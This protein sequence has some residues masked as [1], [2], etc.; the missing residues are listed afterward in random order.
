MSGQKGPQYDQAGVTIANRTPFNKYV[1]NKRQTVN[2]GFVNLAT[3]VG[4]N[5]SITDVL[6][7]IQDGSFRTLEVLLFTEDVP[8]RLRLENWDELA[9]SKVTVGSPG[10]ATAFAVPPLSIT[11]EGAI[12]ATPTL[13]DG[14]TP[15][16]STNGVPFGQ[17]ATGTTV[18]N[19]VKVRGYATA[20]AESI[21]AT[22]SP[23]R[24]DDAALANPTLK[25]RR[26]HIDFSTRSSVT[27]GF[28]TY[29]ASG[30][31]GGKSVFPL[32]LDEQFYTQAMQDAGN[33]IDFPQFEGIIVGIYIS[34]ENPDT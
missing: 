25:W 21:V 29:N 26:S 33:R 30:V 31:I 11:T 27:N 9:F 8:T 1:P 2:D 28:P 12:N 16:T 18:S 19:N 20:F 4:P 22:T 24:Y 5:I 3:F 34:Y 32:I 6:P 14:Y 23:V 10:V 7:M 15:I 17:I 13:I